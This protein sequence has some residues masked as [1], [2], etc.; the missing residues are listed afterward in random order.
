VTQTPHDLDR[1]RALAKAATKGEWVSVGAFVENARDDLPDICRCDPESMGQERWAAESEGFR[2]ALYIAA[3]QPST[4][5]WMIERIEELK[6]GFLISADHGNEFQGSRE[7]N[8]RK[9]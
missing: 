4:V 3:A 6:G 5:L 2:N 7:E 1:L 9:R 8:H